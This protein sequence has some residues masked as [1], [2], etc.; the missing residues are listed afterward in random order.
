MNL[1]FKNHFWFCTHKL[2]YMP[3]LSKFI[4]TPA[5]KGWG[6]PGCEFNKVVEL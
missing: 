4:Y 5:L 1:F 6:T 3:A 2:I